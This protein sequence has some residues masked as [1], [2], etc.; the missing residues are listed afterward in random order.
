MAYH[1][2][3]VGFT[4]SFL[5][6]FCIEVCVNNLFLGEHYANLTNLIGIKVFNIYMDVCVYISTR[7]ICA[8]E[9][10]AALMLS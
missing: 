3:I 1:V 2:I 9:Y 6:Q 7:V 4:F 10:N 8:S 5:L